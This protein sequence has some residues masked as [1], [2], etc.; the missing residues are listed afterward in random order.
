[1]EARHAAETDPTYPKP[2]MLTER[3]TLTL[4]TV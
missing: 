2:K 1:M 4:L 3:P